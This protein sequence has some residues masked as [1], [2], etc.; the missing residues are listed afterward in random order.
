MKLVIPGGSGD[1]PA[2]EYCENLVLCGNGEFDGDQDLVGDCDG[3]GGVA[4]DDWFLP[5]VSVYEEYGSDAIR[6]EYFYD[7]G[8]FV[9]NTSQGYWTGTTVPGYNSDAYYLYSSNGYIS[10]GRKTHDSYFGARCVRSES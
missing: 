7:S 8:N 10:Y 3:K 4:F 9:N 2:C 1:Y 5:E 6:L